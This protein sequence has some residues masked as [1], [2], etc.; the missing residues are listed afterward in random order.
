MINSKKIAMS[1]EQEEVL[2]KKTLLDLTRFLLI[3]K[4]CVDLGI[5]EE[6]ITEG[7]ELYRLNI[8]KIQEMG[9]ILFDEIVMNVSRL[10][11][12]YTKYRQAKR[13][14]DKES[15]D[16]RIPLIQGCFRYLHTNQPLI[17]EF[18]EREPLIVNY[19]KDIIQGVLE[20]KDN[21]SL[22]LLLNIP[23]FLFLK[24]GVKSP[25]DWITSLIEANVTGASKTEKIDT[26]LSINQ[27][28]IN[29]ANEIKS[30]DTKLRSLNPNTSEFKNLQDER[31]EKLTKLIDVVQNSEGADAKN[32]LS[33]LTNV[34]HSTETHQTAVGKRLSLTPEQEN[35]MIVDG[36]S[37]IAAGAGSGKTR[38]LAGRVAWL[39]QEKGVPAS[40]IM[41]TSFTA[42]SATE[43]KERIEKPEFA[44]EGAIQGK[45]FGTSHS[46]AFSI[47]QQYSPVANVDF[48]L[49][50]KLVELAL[51]QVQMS[52]ARG[53]TVGKM[54]NKPIFNQYTENDLNNYKAMISTFMDYANYFVSQPSTPPAEKEEL[55]KDIEV[56]KG[57]LQNRLLP[58]DL[59]KEQKDH[60]NNM[61]ASPKGKQVFNK[62]INE[63]RLTQLDRIQK[64]GAKEEDQPYRDLQRESDRRQKGKY[65]KESTY[66]STP[67]NMW[68]NLGLNNENIESQIN[69][70]KNERLFEE[71]EKLQDAYDEFVQK[72]DEGAKFFHKQ[73][74]KCYNN[75]MSVKQLKESLKPNFLNNA[76]V[77]VYGAYLWLKENDLTFTNTLS[78]D[79]MLIK[80]VGLML[81]KPS[82]LSALQNQYKHIMVDE[83]QDLNKSQHIFFGLIAGTINPGNLMPYTDGRP[84]RAKSFVLIGDDK[85]AI[86]EFRGATPQTFIEKSDLLQGDFK[87]AIIPT[88]FRS[89]NDIVDSANK[90]IEYNDQI[91]MTCVSVPS[92]GMGSIYVEKTP[93][94]SF[95][96]S[97]L[98]LMDEI[99]AHLSLGGKVE[100][101][102]V[103]T[104]SKKQAL[105]F[106][107]EALKE[108]IPFRSQI[109]PLAKENFQAIFRWLEFISLPDSE[110]SKLNNLILELYKGGPV[111]FLGEK[112]FTEP[113][114]EYLQSNKNA[115]LL[116]DMPLHLFPQT[117][118]SFVKS[119]VEKY[120]GVLL[121]ARQ[122]QGKAIDCLSQLLKLKDVKKQTFSEVFFPIQVDEVEEG[123]EDEEDKSNDY[124][125]MVSLLD[126]S[127]N[128]AVVT[129]ADVIVEIKKFIKS[130]EEGRKE[131]KGMLIDT[132][133]QWKG[134]ECKYLTTIFANNFPRMKGDDLTDEEYEAEVASERRLAY[135][136]L[137]RGQDQ[138]RVLSNTAIKVWD[139][140]T[141]S[142]KL[143]DVKQSRFID[144][145]CI[146]EKFTAEKESSLKVPVED[147]LHFM[148]KK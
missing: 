1:D 83:A 140:T 104:R 58:Y 114:K 141:K 25:Q 39:I 53:A 134:L 10:N 13:S 92:K 35:A 40:S 139:K 22:K 148:I 15:L 14:Y 107:L 30:L 121:S 65:P 37:I 111:F 4:K 91:P 20:N 99:K 59:S 24:T 18:G 112:N 71:A 70:L 51:K 105:P 67:A 98:R 66:F 72:T 88:N 78:G 116:K 54:S 23:S 138:V 36:K 62:L 79:D 89:G 77:A 43:L 118:T 84:M 2:D 113:V 75:V 132:M 142:W 146:A 16:D 57:I 5:P 52:P 85:Q 96:A 126:F 11:P 94:P 47:L 48:N 12:L 73:V 147:L 101:Y 8:S 68:F 60:L 119:S 110:V 38:V 81:E 61:I 45:G 122:I 3:L 50:S 31:K 27:S 137:T 144:E 28:Y 130:V 125:I 33:N 103:A 19:I 6:K 100:D 76:L 34:I 80:A 82:V 128:P 136:A 29:V 117:A 145:A 93:D 32:I 120:L 17:L 56:L 129:L 115:N 7:L 86:Y 127:T 74:S 102:G 55:K 90:L 124:S 21:E 64:I 69:L 123:E 131:N 9:G 41:A 109:N 143:K 133:H 26:I 108:K 44:G 46:I 97:A 63:Y 106:L 95:E 87:T 42:N 49:D 135:V